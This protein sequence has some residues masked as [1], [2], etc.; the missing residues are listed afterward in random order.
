[1]SV[2]SIKSSTVPIRLSF[3]LSSEAI[4]FRRIDRCVDARNPDLMN[5]GNAGLYRVRG[6]GLVGLGAWH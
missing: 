2:L 3:E 4:L 6:L 5:L 1:M